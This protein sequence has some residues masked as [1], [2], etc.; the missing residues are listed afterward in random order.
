MQ[1][2]PATAEVRERAIHTLNTHFQGTT[3][4]LGDGLK[5]DTTIDK[6]EIDD[7]YWLWEKGRKAVECRCRDIKERRK[8]V[9]SIVLATSEQLKVLTRY[10]GQPF[11]DDEVLSK[12]SAIIGTRP[13]V[14]FVAPRWNATQG[15]FLPILSPDHFVS[16]GALWGQLM[17]ANQLSKY[18]VIKHSI[19]LKHSGRLGGPFNCLACAFFANHGHETLAQVGDSY[20]PDPSRNWM[21]LLDPLLGDLNATGIVNK[22]TNAED[23]YPY[24][25]G[26]L[27]ANLPKYIWTESAPVL[28]SEWLNSTTGTTSARQ[29]S[30]PERTKS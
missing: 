8:G 5:S 11:V 23:K 24:L 27:K 6:A 13:L 15:Q 3:W 20:K 28:L 25:A 19:V 14:L 22:S 4:T 9:T 10:L 17:Q 1:L 7:P 26:K 16:V 18:F 2:P 29:R 12:H 30:D 21:H